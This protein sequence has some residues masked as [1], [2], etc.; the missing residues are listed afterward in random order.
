[1]TRQKK[2]GVVFQYDMSMDKHISAIVKSCC[3][4]LRDFHLICPL[5]SKIAATTLAN[6]FEYSHLDYC[7]SLFYGLS[8]YSIH[9]LLKIKNRT[10]RIVTRTSRFTYL[11]HILKSL[12]W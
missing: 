12:H 5:I 4:Q 7:N 8:K 3:F 6:A 2:V 9:H 11:I 10:A 1:M